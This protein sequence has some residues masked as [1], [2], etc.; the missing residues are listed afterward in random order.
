MA[1]L[2]RRHHN[3][4]VAEREYVLGTHADEIERLA[5]QHRV[6]RA[7]VHDAW[8]RAGFGIGQT[9]LDVGC[10][11]GYA[12][13]DLAEIVGP[14]GRVLA[15]DKSARFLEA[16]TTGCE[17]RGVANVSAQ[18]LD[19]DEAELPAKG[20]DGAWVRW[21]FAFV[22]RPRELV[23]GLARALRPGARLVLHE[24]FDYASWRLLPRSL[25][26]EE[27][28]RVVMESWRGSGGEPDIGL[29]LPA[30]L[31]ELGFELGELRPIVDVV[32]PSSF[33][34][35]WPRAFIQVGLQR[36]VDLGRLDHERAALLWSSF[37]ERER[38]PGTLMATPAVL[39]I[40]AT[41]R[42]G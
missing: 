18:E 4:A 5:L 19:L 27:F 36:M 22:R 8:L 11:P 3:P 31:Q 32:P 6:W 30:W 33:V 7:R 41:R 37:E 39:E 29:Q 38:A 23:A 24:Y 26:H 42:S 28:V 2:A 15:F 9:L 14:R 21:V 1:A 10:G 40:I 35:Q 25:E 20:A 34:W 17:R 16:L 13:V 12:A